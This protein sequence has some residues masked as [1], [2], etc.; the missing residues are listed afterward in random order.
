MD[1]FEL[2][3]SNFDQNLAPLYIGSLFNEDKSIKGQIIWDCLG[4]EETLDAED[5]ELEE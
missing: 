3:P 4:H 5:A 1:K 2:Q